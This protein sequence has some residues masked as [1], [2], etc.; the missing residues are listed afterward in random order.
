MI[1]GAAR[2]QP[3]AQGHRARRAAGGQAPRGRRP[4]VQ[5]LRADPREHLGGHP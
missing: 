1:L 5:A 2:R 4:Q 3:R